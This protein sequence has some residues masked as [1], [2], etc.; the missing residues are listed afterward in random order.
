MAFQFE[1]TRIDKIPTETVLAELERVAELRGFVA[2]GK[3]EFSEAAT[4]SSSTVVRT[5]GSWSNALETLRTALRKRGL[6]LQPRSRG[7]FSEVELFAEMERIWASLGHRPSRIEW[8]AGQPRISYQTYK[9]YF[10]GWQ[11]ACLMFLEQRTESNRAILQQQSVAAGEAATER[12]LIKPRAVRN[13]RDVPPGLRLRV[14]ERDRFR[15][16][17]C[18]SSPITDLTVALHVD[19]VIPFVRGGKTVFENL[20]T[21]CAQCNLEKGGRTDVCPPNV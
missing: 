8:E 14:Y 4:L 1:R 3:R 12:A 10:G 13:P 5:F 18:G 17:Y 7:Y 11:Q 20:Q 6:E 2:F 15:C 21:L 9:R 16:V 19:H